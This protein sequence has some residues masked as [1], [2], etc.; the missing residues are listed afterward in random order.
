LEHET[1]KFRYGDD[2][3]E[4]DI[5]PSLGLRAELMSRT[6]WRQKEPGPFR[7]R[8]QKGSYKYDPGAEFLGIELV[9]SYAG[10]DRPGLA[11]EGFSATWPETL[12]TAA[13]YKE[14][15]LPYGHDYLST[16]GVTLT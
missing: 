3:N 10:L 12:A 16:L 8:Y 11:L 4:V 15:N 6:T 9:G 14:R 7:G 5:L 1:G 13:F 2:G